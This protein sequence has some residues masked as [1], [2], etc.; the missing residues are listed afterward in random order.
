MSRGMQGYTRQN[1]QKYLLKT[2]TTQNH[3]SKR[4]TLV[5]KVMQR[6]LVDFTGLANSKTSYS[7]S[8]SGVGGSKRGKGSN[9]GERERKDKNAQHN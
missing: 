5:N 3:T 9:N 8:L 1:S 4:E 6:A 2:T 7:A